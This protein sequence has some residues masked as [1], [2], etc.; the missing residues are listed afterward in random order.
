MRVVWTDTAR[1]H[2]A[3]IHEYIAHDSPRY[4]MRMVDRLLARSEQLE[5]FPESGRMV[6]EYDDPRI[7]Q[8]IEPPYRIIYRVRDNRIDVLAV[9]HSARQSLGPDDP[10]IK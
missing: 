4:A 9:V 6:P 5:Q 10:R 1:R 3:A 7:R 2:L 8:L